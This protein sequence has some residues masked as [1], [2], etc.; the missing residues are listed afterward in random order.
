MAVAINN[1]NDTV[2][3]MRRQIN[4]LSL[5]LSNRRTDGGI[6]NESNL[7]K[8]IARCYKLNDLVEAICRECQTNGLEAT[9]EQAKQLPHSI[10]EINIGISI[11]DRKVMIAVGDKPNHLP[12]ELELSQIRLNLSFLSLRVKGKGW[13]TKGK[14]WQSQKM[15]E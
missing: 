1:L 11:L 2:G 15:E 13:Q 12:S 7:L 14:G 8:D 3:E 9:M 10:S 5:A 4:E 6:S